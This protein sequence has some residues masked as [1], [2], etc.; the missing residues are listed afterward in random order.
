[1]VL[2]GG[3][4]YDEGDVTRLHDSRAEELLCAASELA[5]CA[6]GKN[7]EILG[8]YALQCLREG[9]G[10]GTRKKSMKIRIHTVKQLKL[11]PGEI[12]R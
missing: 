8:W 11:V 1:M 4:G 6:M 10:A 7:E 2:G 9:G 12:I 5:M 3:G